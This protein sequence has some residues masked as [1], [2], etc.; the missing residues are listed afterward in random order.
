ML[1]EAMEMIEENTFKV[2]NSRS[3]QAGPVDIQR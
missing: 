2:Q 3:Y 1:E